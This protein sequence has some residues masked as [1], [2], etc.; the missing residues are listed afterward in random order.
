M[1][2]NFCPN[3]KSK[4]FQEMVSALGGEE[5]AYFF[6]MRNQGNPLDKA[7][8][9]ADSKLFNS[10]LEQFDGDR[11]QAIVEKAKVYRDQF[12]NSFGDWINNVANISGQ[13]DENGEPTSIDQN[14]YSNK[15]PYEVPITFS[16][17]VELSDDI[18]LSA[19]TGRTIVRNAQ[20]E[21]E[22]IANNILK[23]FIKLYNA[24]ERMPNISESRQRRQTKIYQ[25]ISELKDQHDAK[26]V[27]IALGYALQQL[28][29]IDEG[30]GETRFASGN[31]YQWLLNSSK[32]PEPFS[33]VT[34]EQLIDAYSLGIGFYK[35]LQNAIPSIN[36]K[37]LSREARGQIADFQAALDA[38][39][40]IWRRALFSVV[41]KEMDK[42]I[43]ERLPYSQEEKDMYKEV[44]RDWLAYNFMNGD[45]TS[46]GAFAK[47]FGHSDNPIIKMA[48]RLVQD[49]E[50]VT[51]N[52]MYEKNARL[53]HVLHKCEKNL[54][55]TL[56]K[57]WQT[58]FYEKDDKGVPTSY[59]VTEV[60]RGL[61][62]K[63]YNEFIKQ[64]NE[65]FDNV[66]GFH[67]IYD[68]SGEPRQS[69]TGLR[70]EEE[71]WEKG[72]PTYITYMKEIEKWKSDRINKPYT[73]EYYNEMYSEPYDGLEDPDTAPTWHKRLHG[74]SPKTLI[75]Y[76]RIIENINHYLN[77]CTD[78]ETGIPHPED[79]TDTQYA[80]LEN[81]KKQL[82]ELQN[83]FTED[84]HYKPEEDLKIAYEL[85]AWSKW[86]N[87]QFVHTVDMGSFERERQ[88]VY[89]E[90][91]KTGDFTKLD[92]FLK[93]N[94]TVN[95]NPNFTAQ[96][97]GRFKDLIRA[98]REGESADVVRVRMNK[99][100]LD[101]YVKGDGGIEKDLSSKERNFA[102][103]GMQKEIDQFLEDYGERVRDPEF[104]K[105]LQAE[106]RSK[107]IPYRDAY[108]TAYDVF[109]N[110]VSKDKEDSTELMSY[111]Q[112]LI[113]KFT[114]EAI[115]TG[116][117]I[118][119]QDEH[120]QE[121]PISGSED[122]IRNFVESLFSYTTHDEDP[123]TGQIYDRDI[124]LSIFS[125]SLPISDT[126]VNVKTGE[127]EK[128]ITT[129][130]SERYSSKSGSSTYINYYYDP[131]KQSGEQINTQFDNGRYDNSKEYNKIRKDK[132]LSELYDLIMEIMSE[133][134][135][136]IS[137]KS[138]TGNYLIPKVNASTGALFT[139]LLSRHGAAA[140]QGMWR[141]LAEVRP[142]DED[143]IYSSQDNTNPDGS[144]GTNIPLKLLGVL[145][146]KEN[147]TSDVVGA[148][149]AF[150]HMAINYREKSKILPLLQLMQ[151]AMDDETRSWKDEV[152]GTAYIP[153]GSAQSL[154][155]FNRMM[156]SHVY[157]NS[158]GNIDVSKNKGWEL[159]ARR[160]V[161]AW[162]SIETL[163]MLSLNILSFT[164]GF[165]DSMFKNIHASLVG[166]YNNLFDFA[167]S[168]SKAILRL[169]YMICNLGQQE[170]SCK[171][172]ALMQL[173][174]I[175]KHA[176]EAMRNT[177]HAR[178]NRILAL[179]LMGGFTAT[180]YF[181]NFITL[182]SYLSNCKF[183][184]GDDKLGIK[185]G[186]Y[187]QYELKHLLKNNGVKNPSIKA[188]TLNLLSPVSLANAFEFKSF[189]DA[190]YMSRYVNETLG[191]IN[192]FGKG[193]LRIKDKYKPYVTKKIMSDIRS[194]TLQ[195]SALY[196]G[197]NPDN[198]KNQLTKNPLANIIFGMRRFIAQNVQ[199]LIAGGDDFS[200]REFEDVDDSKI[201][202]GRERKSFTKKVKGIKK[203]T[204]EQKNNRKSYNWET[205]TS[206]DQTLTGLYRALVAL[207]DWLGYV[208]NSI[209][210]SSGQTKVKLGEV[211]RYALR[212]TLIWVGMM[213]ALIFSIISS[214]SWAFKNYDRPDD[215]YEASPV[216]DIQKPIESVNDISRYWNQRFIGNE[217][218]KI[219]LADI[220]FRTYESQ[221]TGVNPGTLSEFI[222]SATV[223][224]TG[225]D[226][227]LGGLKWIPSVM[228]GISGDADELVKSGGY[229]HFTKRERDIWKSV[230]PLRNLHSAFTGPGLTANLK[231]YTDTY[232][233]PI[234]TV[235]GVDLKQ[236]LKAPKKSSFVYKEPDMFED[237]WSNSSTDT[238]GDTFSQDSG[239][240]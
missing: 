90:C 181:A 185:E 235:T 195:R 215:R 13:V 222:T 129:V 213:S 28:G 233:S 88:K 49:A 77:I 103:W 149:S 150:A 171:E 41:G 104:A 106:Y 40:N 125:V 84:L 54:G 62:E 230:G 237:T 174:G 220:L 168:V 16:G 177:N 39:T 131:S 14:A 163:Q 198:D 97:I 79:L 194:K 76:N 33:D 188:F 204:Q 65:K 113:N 72:E 212:S 51:Q 216:L 223:Y 63:D 201:K 1:N 231:Y 197:M 67:Y 209:K 205:N 145:D 211:E 52:E 64:L 122:D 20:Q 157:E 44:C 226:Q 147:Y 140:A 208:I 78:P 165:C 116:K 117:I 214:F 142:D 101:R 144:F 126:F 187:T 183:I 93:Y 60:N 141:N 192:P 180:D 155:M 232:A 17:N 22:E 87:E 26:S 92:K 170:A 179:V 74:L 5:Q 173:F 193:V 196:N 61:Y 121:I 38:A 46:I 219:A 9:G 114:N 32:L 199:H 153:N 236:Y 55:R 112:Y 8:N 239:M 43:D 228:F 47:N 69:V 217:E 132:N 152:G 56:S 176:K 124:P 160:G 159:V 68:E 148:V 151:Y 156:S 12:I 166:K 189:A 53:L 218:Y 207:K 81:W 184:K 135:G 227:Q 95:V 71:T 186:F 108:G 48:F 191:G 111:R 221:M 200:V 133:A 109:M 42:I 100:A 94:S 10:L 86:R 30:S 138:Q 143:Y 58:I 24:Y 161:K 6:W 118:G 70:A 202:H 172:I 107:Q 110:P 37:Y 105:M 146:D 31:I 57:T 190:N 210:G 119:Y 182:N 3:K 25:A 59:W 19:S 21:Q 203:L 75:R 23:Q 134:Y 89:D 137:S 115:S 102:F 229:Q 234:K 27:E 35:Q 29:E 50:S 66:Y 224:K 169:P 80:N 139:R 15:K 85:R 123:D 225:L 162:Q 136:Q 178:T 73:L 91:A 7:P 45:I 99:A 158:L 98:V 83:P 175:T 36:S 238:F 2:L 96:T 154:K 120:G 127:T 18:T 128:T 240:W 82:E 164:V 167:K 206:E 34:T 4:E 130:P 11:K